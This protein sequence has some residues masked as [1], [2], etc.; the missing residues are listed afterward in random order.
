MPEM[1]E[2]LNTIEKAAAHS[3]RI[4]KSEQ[5]LRDKWFDNCVDAMIKRVNSII[6]NNSRET[7]IKGVDDWGGYSHA[8]RRD[9]LENKINEL[10]APDFN[11]SISSHDFAP[12]AYIFV[13]YLNGL[14]LE[15]FK[16]KRKIILD[17]S[18]KEFNESCVRKEKFS[19]FK[20][21]AKNA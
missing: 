3:D 13:Y 16:E 18:L 2:P 17:E 8:N 12:H 15:Q 9:D 7:L 19:L 4:L 6:V 20:W 11:V 1:N 21:I 5:E 14:T 10:F